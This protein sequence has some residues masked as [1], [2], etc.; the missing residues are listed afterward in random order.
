MIHD[1]PL[2]ATFHVATTRSR[3]A[4]GV[5]HRPAAVPGE[6]HR[7]DRRLRRRPQ[8]HRR[9]PRRRCGRHPQRRRGGPLRLGDP[10]ARAPARRRHP[11]ASSGATTS[12]ARAWTSSPPPWPTSP[13]SARNCGCSSPAGATPRSSA[14]RCPSGWGPGSTCSARSASTTRPDCCAAWTSTARRTPA[15]RAS[16]WSCSRRWRPAPRSSRATSRRSGGCSTAVARACS[17]RPATRAR[18]PPRWRLL[19]DDPGRRAALSAA[20]ERAVQ[21]YDWPRVVAQVLR[22][23]ELAIAGAGAAL[24]GRW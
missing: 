4:V 10:A 7:P 5:R 15:R 20:G 23:Y 17:S 11:R 8:G 22:V 16:A 18:W 19:L 3:V 13:R 6:A 24:P 2:V 9:A 12:R 1:G 14:S 21:P